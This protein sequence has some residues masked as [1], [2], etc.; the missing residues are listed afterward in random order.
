[1]STTPSMPTIDTHAHIWDMDRP[2]M[3]WLRQD[4]FFASVARTVTP[5][6]LV[7][8][9]GG[10][11]V[12]GVVLVQA[13]TVV[14]ETVELLAVAA[15]LPQVL[16]VVGWVDLDSAAATRRD[17]E[18]LRTTPGGDRLVGVRH[19]GTGRRGQDALVDGRLAP[20][21][22]VLAEHGL[23][24]DVHMPDASTLG[25][26]A[27]L[28]EQV[29]G[30]RIV[31]N[32]L[33]RPDLRR[34]LDHLDWAG[35]IAR[36]GGCPDLHVK[37][38]GWSTRLRGPDP[39][40]VRPFVGHVLEHVGHERVLFAGNWPVALVSGSYAETLVAS[41]L[42]VDHLDGPALGRVFAGNALRVYRP[43]GGTPTTN[44]HHTMTRSR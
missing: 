10:S 25:A 8:A 18:R 13:A 15:A 39:D 33:G 24:L 37:Y 35:G 43:P 12:A 22:R 14:E 2:W 27:E 38:S 17:L 41:R 5:A 29:P 11:G 1:M 26:V 28:A 4:P 20:A 16:G 44:P 34:G 42:A 32:H 40:A 3:G 19:F 36:L 30:L 7:G 31:L 21:A 23:T 6:D 9:L